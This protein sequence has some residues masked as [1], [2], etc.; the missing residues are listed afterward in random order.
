[1]SK[2]SSCSKNIIM[3]LSSFLNLKEKCEL[4]KVSKNLRNKIDISLIDYKVFSV[5]H[6]EN[7]DN[8]DSLPKMFSKKD[9]EFKNLTEEEFAKSLAKFYILNNIKINTSN[10]EKNE[11]LF[12][13]NFINNY[14]EITIIA[15]NFELEILQKF[16]NFK[17]LNI[18]S[19]VL[20][21]NIECIPDLKE[22]LNLY[23]LNKKCKKFYFTYKNDKYKI[24]ENHIK[25][26]FDFLCKRKDITELSFNLDINY[27]LLDFVNAIENMDLLQTLKLKINDNTFIEDNVELINKE[28]STLV[29]LKKLDLI[30]QKE[31]YEINNYFYLENDQNNKLVSDNDKKYSLLLEKLPNVFFENIEILTL[32]VNSQLINKDIFLKFEKLKELSIITDVIDICFKNDLQSEKILF[33]SPQKLSIK[34]KLLF[35]FEKINY[36]D[37]DN[38]ITNN[39]N[40]KILSCEW[41]LEGRNRN[42]FISFSEDK[43]LL[44]EKIKNECLEELELC[45]CQTRLNEGN[46]S[47][48]FILK[49]NPNLKK[50]KLISNKI[51]RGFC[52]NS[53]YYLLN[54]ELSDTRNLEELE[55]KNYNLIKPNEIFNGKK[56]LTSLKIENGAILKNE[57]ELFDKNISRNFIKNT[58]LNIR[59]QQNTYFLFENRQIMTVDL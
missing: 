12:I 8:F 34:M 14:P 39:N 50:L 43:F 25:N 9:K 19:F 2:L 1:M 58:D 59:D 20:E 47:L 16:N 29:N 56:F 28:L 11:K 10:C 37:F 51:G 4:S 32:N 38:L 48:D 7:P 52:G 18:E 35:S 23:S 21:K 3:Y 53:G 49:N 17:N 41:F 54:L 45:Y 30:I 13:V 46:V 42:N 15:A 5:L 26:I 40:L 36:L 57:R 55:I 24:D 31:Y 44:F 22:V 6:K 27:N 33:E